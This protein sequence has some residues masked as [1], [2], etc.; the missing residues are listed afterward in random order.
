VL[1]L[2]G[3][4]DFSSAGYSAHVTFHTAGM[5]GMM[6]R[7]D[8]D[9]QVTGLFEPGH[10]K[11]ALFQGRGNLRGTERVT[12]IAYDDGNP[13]VEIIKPPVEKERTAVPPA[14]TLH[15]IDTLSA[16]A[17][18]IRNVAD[19]G[20]CDGAVTTFDG[21]RLA[22]QTSHTAGEEDL[23]Q[24]GRSMF[25]GKALR[26]DFEGRQLAGFVT[27]ENEDDLR[28]PRYGTAWLAP[29]LPNAPPVPVRVAFENKILGKVILYLTSVTPQAG[30]AR[31]PIP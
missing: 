17:L 19:T 8:N 7:S 5:V 20:K 22:T 23:P 15:T 11:P 1:K 26:C 25:Q 29:M 28:K 4:V 2:S 21:R 24:T 9:S 31:K 27:D 16:V 13:V 12:R 18:L 3:S 30:P 10:A 14:Q 6:L